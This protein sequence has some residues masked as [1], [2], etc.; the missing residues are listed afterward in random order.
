MQQKTGSV[1]SACTIYLDD[2]AY[3]IAV[4]L[5]HAAMQQE[6][7]PEQQVSER[8]VSKDGRSLP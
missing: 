3:E 2:A 6:L 8:R 5:R 4:N 7:Q 1:E